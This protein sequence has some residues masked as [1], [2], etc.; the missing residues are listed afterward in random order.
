M[1]AR[2]FSSSWASLL[3]CSFACATSFAQ[4]SVTTQ[5]NDI[6]R[7]GQNLTESILTPANVT[8]ANFG[9]LFTLAV[10]GQVYAQPLYLPSVTI[11]GN[12]HRVV[13]TATEHDSVYAFDAST[14]A[15][16]WKASLLDSAHGAASG[17]TTDPE[18]D[19]GC[20]DISALNG[21]SEYGITG[22]PVIDPNT[23]TL[24]VVSKTLE[25]SPAYPVE[26][27]HA[28]DVSTGAEK[29]GGPVLI[30]ASVAGSGNG[31]SGGVM[32]F[33]AKWENQRPGLL[34]LNGTVYL[35]FASHCDY[36]A[37]HGWLLG[38]NATTL[39]QN[40]VFV[41]TPNGSAS[42]IWMGGSG[43]AADVQN[44]IGRLFPATGNGTYDAKTPYGT[45]TMDYGDD[46]LRL[47]QSTTGALT[48]A[49]AFTPDNQA[50]LNSADADVA[51]GGV[52]LLPD[53]TGANPHLLV[54][55]GKS[56]SMYVVN[57]DSM[58]GYST[59]ANNIVQ[60]VTTTGG[61]WGM[62]AY[63]NGNVYVWPASGKLSQYSVTNGTLSASPVN[64]S[65]QS[66]SAWYGSTPSISAN[67]ATN[68]IVWSLDWSQTPGVLYAHN[69]TNVSQ[70]LWSSSQ[71][72]ARDSAGTPVKFVVPT[73][74]DGNVFV[75]ADNQVDIYGLL[76]APVPDFSLSDFPGALRIQPGTS[77][78][79]QITLSPINGFTGT[80]TF[81]AAGLPSGVT[82]SF[83][84]GVLNLYTITLTAAANAPLTS[85]DAVATLTG[86]SGSLTHSVPLTISVS[87]ATPSTS[88]NMTS[89]FNV[90]G[91]FN[92]GSAVTNGG[93]DTASTAY[94]ANLLGPSLAALN[95]YFTFGTPGTPNAASNTTIPLASGN[96]G[97]LNILGTG[98]NGNQANQSF[99]VKY[100]DGTSTTFTQSLSDWFTPQSY[101]GETT[102]SAMAYRLT[103]TGATD[104][105]TFNLY[106]YSLAL[107]SA[108]TVQS[109]ILPA[110]R[111]VVILATTL[112][113]PA[114]SSFTLSANPGSLA[115]TQGNSV[116]SSITVNPLNGF[117]GSVSLTATGL[118]SGVTAAFGTNPTTGSSVLTL[119][120][121][122]AA[123]T[124]AATITITGMSGTVA[125]S[126]T[127]GLTVNAPAQPSFTLSSSPSA[128]STSQGSSTTSTISVVPANGFTGGVTL[129]A[130]GLPAGV[131]ASFGTNPVTGSGVLTLTASTTATSGTATV[132]VKGTSGTLAASTTISLT[133][134]TKNVPVSLASA[135][136][137]SSA[138][139]TNGRTFTTG[140]L[141]RQGY[142]YSASLLGASLTFNGVPF[143][144]GAAN[145]ADAT[146]NT[147][148]TLPAG[149]Y[150]GLAFLGTGVNGN[151]ASQRFVV[152]YTDGST[153]SFTQSVSDW[154]TPQNYGGESKAVTMSYRDRSNG[155]TDNRTF[156]LYGYTFSLNSAKTVRS[157]R[158]PANR[159]AVVLAITMIGK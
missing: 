99:V 141:D 116:T 41:S 157:I 7:T 10:D 89:A 120:A 50:A 86:T 28:L 23:G 34:L 52:L 55:L 124:G 94:S 100:T 64:V 57:R 118:P 131:T 135:F 70:L 152:T 153:T 144:L 68:G 49:D 139:V 75:G 115:V 101:T 159:N 102:V 21:G 108:K 82:A 18:S 63:W 117:T 25:G 91:I 16:L 140:G 15:Q 78:T 146:D 114:A 149:Q 104:N 1:L 13:F 67:G 65:A 69:A 47:T 87:N 4:T 151:Q 79:V 14:G 40:A 6:G 73:I 53:Q 107:N 29:L 54:Q 125:A 42:G 48:V 17:A 43:I 35:G 71:N 150:S 76:V 121:G 27:L 143:T 45:N 137:I 90:Y 36:S 59:S 62:P 39:A 109:L 33:D 44:S 92:T 12:A 133:I 8:T 30:Q 77:T 103:A 61:L 24:Y 98:L 58:G 97:T 31:S 9:K 26:R 60:T 110:N 81:S 22:T 93:I 72:T 51:S 85:T 136:N 20:G 127:I 19:T 38:Y 154:Y 123:A 158:L 156:Y 88:V 95:A 5:H 122:S 74:A 129:A 66:Q 37:W 132:T 3:L 113:A 11:G 130:S 105:R 147:T 2:P 155:T 106:G 46:I 126:T 112:S 128:V 119:T 56:G 80:P 83:S 84:S 145:A 111:N 138:I 148:I 142:S 32:K 134:T 96:F